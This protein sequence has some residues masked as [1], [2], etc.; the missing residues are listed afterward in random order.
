MITY[1]FVAWTMV[2]VFGFSLLY[3]WDFSWPG[4]KWLAHVPLLQFPLW[5]VYENLIADVNIR[6]DLAWILPGLL[7]AALV[8]ASKLA[9]LLL[10]ENQELKNSLR[11][12][13]NAKSP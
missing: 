13:A 10:I 3:P 9:W 6:V 7:V 1:Q 4:A 11:S 8:Y 2:A 5:R 12:R